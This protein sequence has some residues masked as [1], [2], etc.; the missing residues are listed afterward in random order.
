MNTIT[1]SLVG[2]VWQDVGAPAVSI[3]FD[4]PVIIGLLVSTVLPLLVALVTKVVT[5]PGIKAALLAAFSAATGLL[6]ELGN[7]LAAGTTYNLGMGLIFALVAFIVGVA[8]HVGL[9]KPT[10]AAVRTQAIGY[11]PGNELPLH[12]RGNA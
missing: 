4:W 7:S 3:A 8:M 9:W 6:T 11:G 1:L 10:T 2:G 12:L 5:H